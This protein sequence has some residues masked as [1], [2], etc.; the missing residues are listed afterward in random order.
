M[1]SEPR[2]V[3]DTNSLI[4]IALLPKSTNR[5]A[6]QKAEQLGEIVLSNEVL[7]ELA[8]VLLRT[9]FDKYLTLEERLEFVERIETRY[10]CI[11]VTSAFTDC[12]DSKD[13]KFLNLAFDAK[14]SC[15]ITGDKDLLVL[16]PFRNIPILNATDF[17]NSF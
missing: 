8:E 17:L 3:F 10:K 11:E 1:K 2:F 16:N 15:L 13:N 12:R 5:S 14:A 6:L 7:S 4:S 9:K